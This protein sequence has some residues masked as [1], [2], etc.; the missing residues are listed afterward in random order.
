M[1]TALVLKDY[2]GPVREHGYNGTVP[3][4]SGHCP[5]VLA[6]VV[7]DIH[8]QHIYQAVLIQTLDN[9]LLSLTQLQEADLQV[10]DE[11]N[12]IALT[13][14]E[15]FIWLL[16]PSLGEE[17]DQTDELISLLLISKVQ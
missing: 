11:P 1:N 7:C 8:M 17:E 5:I 4:N 2:R 13:P 10:N 12:H 16:I 6:V 9:N 14:S 15:S 3:E